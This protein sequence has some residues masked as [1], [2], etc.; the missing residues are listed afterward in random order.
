MV[1]AVNVPSSHPRR[2]SCRIRSEHRQR[3]QL[4]HRQNTESTFFSPTSD[5]QHQQLYWCEERKWVTV[6]SNFCE[7]SHLHEHRVI[8]TKERKQI[9]TLQAL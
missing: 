5:L 6:R 2:G 3:E 1:C 9:N 4:E 8:S 7:F